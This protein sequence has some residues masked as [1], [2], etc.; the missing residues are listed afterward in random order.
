[1]FN[2]PITRAG[3]DAVGQFAGNLLAVRFSYRTLAIHPLRFD[4]VEPGTFGRQPARHYLYAPLALPSSCKG[5]A[6]VRSPLSTSCV[7]PG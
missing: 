4:V 1:M 6:V 2:M 3:A 5:A 7:P